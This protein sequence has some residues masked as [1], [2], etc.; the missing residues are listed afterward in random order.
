[1]SFRRAVLALWAMSLPLLAQQ[2]PPTSDTFVNSS[3]PNTNYRTS[4]IDAV[5]SN[6]TTF[7]KF[8]LAGVP[9]GS[10]IKKATLRLYVDAVTSSGQFDVYNLS[11]TLELT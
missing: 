9:T 8:N 5:R 2:A 10:T 4:V 3:S 7:M 1:M 6:T 11:A